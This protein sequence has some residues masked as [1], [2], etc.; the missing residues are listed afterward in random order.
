MNIEEL[1]SAFSEVGM[2]ELNILR[3]GP[4]WAAMGTALF[5]GERRSFIS[6]NQPTIS[7]ALDEVVAGAREQRHETLS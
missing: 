1:E 4:R 5:S 2:V 7:D 6:E 3:V